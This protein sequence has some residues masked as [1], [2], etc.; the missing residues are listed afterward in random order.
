MLLVDWTPVKVYPR[1]LRVVSRINTK[2]LIGNGLQ[3]NDEWIDINTSVSE[4]PAL[5]RGLLIEGIIVHQK[6]LHIVSQAPRLP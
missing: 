5:K 1:A 3:E 2:T 6:H 4:K